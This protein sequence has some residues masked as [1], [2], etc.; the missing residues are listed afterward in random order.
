MT[1]MA[2]VGL[3]VRALAVG[4]VYARALF[5]L[6]EEM[7]SSEEALGELDGIVEG[8]RAEPAFAEFFASPL[9]DSEAR[10]EV[11]EKA[12]RGRA[13]D[14]VADG[15]QVMNRKGRLSLL[16]A[17]AEAF[18]HELER[19]RGQIEVQ[20]TTAVEL[21]AAL[22]ERLIEAVGK[23]TGKEPQLAARVD[24]ELLGGMVLTVGDRKVD[25]SVAGEIQ[26]LS[27]RLQGLASRTGAATE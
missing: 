25:A 14:L 15:L 13:S 2:A 16:P 1:E 12:L 18:R 9:V 7:E 20:V 22:R 8:L 11:L 23:V 27:E 3:D 6:S 21:S 24:P 17:V 5:S 10:R 26:R 4:R 19:A